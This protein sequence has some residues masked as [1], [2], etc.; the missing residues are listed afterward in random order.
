MFF[1]LKYEC[2]CLFIA[3]VFIEKT[4]VFNV[5]SVLVK[6]LALKLLYSF[7]VNNYF[8][9]FFIECIILFCVT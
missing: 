9:N 5:A 4:Y 3:S 6:I 8:I 2:H 7:F 1:L